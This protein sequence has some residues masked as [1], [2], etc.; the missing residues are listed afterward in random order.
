LYKF[1]NPPVPVYAGDIILKVA[2]VHQGFRIDK[3]SIYTLE[4]VW[5]E[6]TT[7]SKVITCHGQ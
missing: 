2:P 3:R 6:G 1:K 5:Y 4:Y 7:I